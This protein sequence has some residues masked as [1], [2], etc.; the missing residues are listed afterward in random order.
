MTSTLA[1]KSAL[2]V[3]EDF[4]HIIPLYYKALN[5]VFLGDFEGALVECRRMDLRIS[6]LAQKHRSEKKFRRDAFVHLLMGVIYELH[7]LP[8]DAFIA[9]RNA[10]EIYT[11][12][13]ATLFNVSPPQQL[14]K[15]MARAAYLSGFMDEYEQIAQS[16]SSVWTNSDEVYN[17]R[18]DKDKG[19]VVLFW[20]NGLGPYKSETNL[21]FV[22][23]AGVGGVMSLTSEEGGVIIPFSHGVARAGDLMGFSSMRIS[24]PKYVERPLYYQDARVWVNG[25]AYHFELAEDVN[26]IAFKV[27]RQRMVYEVTKAVVR[28]AA[29]EVVKGSVTRLDSRLALLTDIT[30]LLTEHADTRGWQT[31]PHAIYYT[32]LPLDEGTYEMKIELF[33]RS[34][35][36]DKSETFSVQAYPGRT[37]LYAYSSM[38]THTSRQ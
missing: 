2:Y 17:P 35:A 14:I 34:A 16:Y 13:Y 32:R 38:Q 29:K 6:L 33:G 18:T 37:S 1:P 4:E 5:Y 22:K 28:T 36:Q 24:F 11:S 8:N 20:N 31:S 15:D 26:A 3:G 19:H 30:F 21:T 9:Y 12:D 25:L 7:D 23:T 10:Y 27:L